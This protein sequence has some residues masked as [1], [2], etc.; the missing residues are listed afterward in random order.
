MIK[1]IKET[2]ILYGKDAKRFLNAVKENENK[3][4]SKKEYD[5]MH[6]DYLKLKNISKF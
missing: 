2:P 6:D 1:E 4:I 5:I 3:K